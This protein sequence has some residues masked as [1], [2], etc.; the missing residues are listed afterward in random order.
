MTSSHCFT[1]KIKLSMLSMDDGSHPLQIQSINQT[2]TH[3]IR[4]YFIYVILRRFTAQTPSVRSTVKFLPLSSKIA[5]VKWINKIIR[6]L[7]LLIPKVRSYKYISVASAH[8]W[9]VC[10]SCADYFITTYLYDLLMNNGFRSI[11]K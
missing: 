5:L 7:I 2:G 8:S 9:Y 11:L 4:Y 10:L 6:Y 3:N 1:S